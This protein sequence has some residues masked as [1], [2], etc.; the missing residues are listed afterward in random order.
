MRVINFSRWQTTDDAPS[1][2]GSV[3]ILFLDRIRI[4]LRCS[5]RLIEKFFLTS[6][7]QNMTCRESCNRRLCAWF[8]WRFDRHSWGV[9][10]DV[11]AVTTMSLDS[12]GKKLLKTSNYSLSRTATF[13]SLSFSEKALRWT[14][15]ILRFRNF[16]CRGCFRAIN[17]E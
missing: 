12:R 3:F 9:N 7:E 17:L 6:A 4:H 11:R 10:K 2:T 16:S 5:S 14:K 8:S 1:Q 15:I 13:K